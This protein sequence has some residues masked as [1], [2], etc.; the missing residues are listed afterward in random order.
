MSIQAHSALLVVDMQNDFLPGGS[1][2]VPGGEATI[3][4]INAYIELFRQAGRPILASRDWHPKETV[5]FQSGGGLWPPHC[6]QNTWGA[7]FAPGLTLPEDVVVMSKGM[8]PQADG[9]SAFMAQDEQG[10]SLAT[11][12]QSHGIQHLYVAGLALDYCV[13]ASSMDAIKLGLGVTVLIDGTRA[14]NRNLHDAEETIEELVRA[15]GTI[16]TMVQVRN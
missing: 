7:E 13:R 10:R 1:L 15:G 5:H 9:Y 4:V 3:P 2:G 8:D 6:I 12:L 11:W 14:V 16:A